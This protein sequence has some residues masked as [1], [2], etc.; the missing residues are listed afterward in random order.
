MSEL[1]LY[2]EEYIRT[3]RSN[4]GMEICRFR[5]KKRLS[6]EQ[7]ASLMGISRA[8]ISKIENGRFAISVDYLAKFAWHL[9]FDIKLLEK[10]KP[11]QNEQSQ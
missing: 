6:Q 9:E 3:N 11:E 1:Q 7:L 2:K 10:E 8:T 5:A 4:I